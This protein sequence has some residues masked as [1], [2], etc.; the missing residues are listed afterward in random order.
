MGELDA[1][2]AT[3]PK[4]A[5]FLLQRFIDHP[6][7]AGL[8]YVRKANTE[9]GRLT[10][11]TLRHEPHVIGDGVTSI[12]SLI[13]AEPRLRHKRHLYEACLSEHDLQLIAPHG[14]YR[15]LTNIASFRV[16]ARYED[17]SSLVTPELNTKMDAIC[18]SM[19]RFHFGRFDVKFASIAELQAGNFIIM[20]VNGAGSEA[21]QFWDP[22]LRM[23]HSFKGVF[24]KQRHLFALGDAMRRAGH[25][26]V[27][28]RALTRAHLK[29]QKLIRRYPLSN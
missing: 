15:R 23:L 8:F 28:W 7:E 9:S 10:G 24:A 25:A 14:E 11:M 12:S 16:G 29:Q 20:E 18:R 1:Y 22:S 19:D 5:A 6:H 26:P 3:F 2:A 4:D 17:A 21:I 13:D 27:G